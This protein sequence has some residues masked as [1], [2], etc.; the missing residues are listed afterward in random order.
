M[1]QNDI[2]VVFM[3]GKREKC[4]VIYKSKSLKM[5]SNKSIWDLSVLKTTD[6]NLPSLKLA[7]SLP[8]KGEYIKSF[9]SK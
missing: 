9:Y 3:N 6:L 4:E 1:F 2:E 5:G 8:K 7:S